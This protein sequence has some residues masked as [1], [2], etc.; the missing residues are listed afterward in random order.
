M[1]RA[2]SSSRE[3]VR[4]VDLKNNTEVIKELRDSARSARLIKR[5]HFEGRRGYKNRTVFFILHWT[6]DKNEIYPPTPWMNAQNV[7]E[8]LTDRSI[9]ASADFA[10]GG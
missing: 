10:V 4:I 7:A 6:V 3:C 8:Y 5:K 2:V 9:A 1:K